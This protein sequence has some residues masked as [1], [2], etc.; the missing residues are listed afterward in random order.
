MR[1]LIDIESSSR[2]TVSFHTFGCRLNQSESDTLA[3]AFSRDQAGFL[4]M[5]ASTG[6]SD[7]AVINT[8]S[9]T[10]SAEAKCR[11]LIRKIIRKSPHTFIAVTGCYAQV[12]VAAL[13]NIPGIDLIAG[14]EYKMLLPSLIK[15]ATGT[16]LSKLPQPM[17]FHTPKIN[18][19]DFTLPAYAVFD[20]QTR[21]NI[22]IQDGCDFFCSF[23]IIPYTRGR[24]RSRQWNDILLE[25]SIWAEQ[26]YKELVLTGVNLGEYHYEGK[27]LAD[28]VEALEQIEGLARIR[29]SSIE[30]TT[31]SPR[32]FDRMK[33][34]QLCPYLHLPLQSGSNAVLSNMG[35][36]YTRE[37]YIAFVEEAL[38]AV[39]GLCLGTDVMVGFPGEGEAEFE[40]TV[41]LLEQLPFAYAHCFPFSERKGTRVTRMGLP[42]VSASTM[43]ARSHRLLE[44]SHRKKR[45]FYEAAIGQTVDLLFEGGNKNGVVEG[46]TANYIRVAVFAEGDLRHQ[47]LPV[48]IESITEE[49]LAWGVLEKQGKDDTRFAL[50]MV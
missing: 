24:E 49:G 13:S 30:P 28:L 36:R 2:S 39:P 20:H 35:R 19:D 9:V 34:G 26:G 3:S 38:D 22:K 4:P 5:A 33:N 6:G 16:T 17:I 8:C 7:I 11:N 40:E 37:A 32:L 48:R 43:K 41:S 29:I 12:G 21:P 50:P 42:T 15:K 10:E 44:L 47:I 1:P 23:C 18:R 25:A 45:A 27:G 31:L 46:L 14:T